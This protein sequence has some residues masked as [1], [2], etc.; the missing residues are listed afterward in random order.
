MDSRFRG[1]D[2][3]YKGNLLALKLSPSGKLEKALAPFLR[4]ADKSGES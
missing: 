2:I 1:N 3:R 4:E